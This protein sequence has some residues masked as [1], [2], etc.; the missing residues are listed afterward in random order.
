LIDG[1]RATMLEGI[2][3]TS[4]DQLARM[5]WLLGWGAVTFALALR[6]FRWN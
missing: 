2:P 4:P 6:W 1:L 3:L 5:A